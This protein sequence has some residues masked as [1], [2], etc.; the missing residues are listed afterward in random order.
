LATLFDAINIK[1]NNPTNIIGKDI[2]LPEFLSSNNNQTKS[3]ISHKK[4]SSK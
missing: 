2:T 4:F 1:N 3:I